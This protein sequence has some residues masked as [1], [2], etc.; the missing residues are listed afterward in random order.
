MVLSVLLKS[1]MRIR[2][3]FTNVVNNISTNCLDGSHLR[4]YSI[5]STYNDENNGG[6]AYYY[7]NSA[8]ILNEINTLS[9]Y[10][11]DMLKDQDK[12]DALVVLVSAAGFPEYAEKIENLEKAMAE[13]KVALTAP[14]ASID[15]ESKDLDN[16]I[17]ALMG[18]GET[19]EFGSVSDPALWLDSEKFVINAD[20][21]VTISVSVQTVGCLLYTSQSQ[22][23]S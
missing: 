5:I 20:N 13:V 15:V 14:N 18:N 16:L 6:L 8:M 7:K 4:I 22:Y 9:G 17:T 1:A 21:K 12:K 10:L 3:T 23:D 19:K 11:S 2:H